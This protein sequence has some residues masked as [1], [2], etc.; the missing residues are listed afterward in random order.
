MR[1][2]HCFSE[3]PFSKDKF[4]YVLVKT[5]KTSGRTASMAPRCNPGHDAKYFN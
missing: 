3:E 1:V 4:E 5:L 2:H